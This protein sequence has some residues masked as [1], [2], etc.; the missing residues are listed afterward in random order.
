MQDELSDNK[1]DQLE[2]VKGTIDERL[3]SSTSIIKKSSCKNNEV[4]SAMNQHDRE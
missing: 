3:M 2:A 1:S 4:K